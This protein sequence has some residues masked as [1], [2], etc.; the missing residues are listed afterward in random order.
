MSVPYVELTPLFALALFLLVYLR[1][2]PRRFYFIRHGQTVLNAQHIRQGQEGGLSEEGREQAI[3]VGR[4]LR[5]YSPTGIISSSYERARE[6]SALINTELKVPV[7]YS[8]LFVERKNPSEIIGKHRD[9]PEVKRI[10]DEME[11]A[12]HTDD[13]HYSDEESFIELKKRARKSL[14]LL[15]RQGVSGT[16]VVTHHVFLKMLLSYMLYRENLRASDFVKLSFFN[17]SDNATVTTC[18][19]H[20]WK[21]FSKTRGWYV[22]AYN[23]HPTA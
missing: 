7:L 2:R 5:R 8:S 18:D 1:M 14:N 15:A 11:L 4:Y 23:E 22:V 16:V 10:I 21:M 12:Y 9:L 6:T 20:P 13:Y 17:F 3:Q 19:F